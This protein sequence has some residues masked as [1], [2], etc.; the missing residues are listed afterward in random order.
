MRFRQTVC[1]PTDR[2]EMGH[3][4]TEA[5]TGKPS[6]AM[7]RWAVIAVDS[8]IL[9]AILPIALVISRS[10]VPVA[11]EPIPASILWIVAVAGCIMIMGSFRAYSSLWR[12]ASSADFFNLAIATIA[13]TTYLFIL[14]IIAAM[15]SAT[16]A[17]EWRFFAAF[18]LLHAVLASLV[19][20]GYRL[21]SDYLEAAKQD[22]RSDRL[23]TVFVG[24]AD[25]AAVALKLYRS[26]D[27]S[28]PSIML[29]V[30]T[31]RTLDGRYLSGVR[32]AGGMASIGSAIARLQRSD[33]QVTQGL[34]G[35]RGFRSRA[36]RLD[37]VVR[38]RQLGIAVREFSLDTVGQ[39][40][41]STHA[42]SSSDIKSFINRTEMSFPETLLDTSVAGKRVLVTG[43]A[44]SIGTGLSRHCLKRGALHV[45][46]ADRSEFGVFRWYREVLAP[47][48]GLGSGH[49]AEIANSHIMTRLLAETRPDIVFH[50]AALKH[51]DLV[52][53]N[54]ASALMTNVVGTWTTAQAAIS[55]GAGQFVFVSTDKA[56]D[57][58]TLLGLTKRTGEILSASLDRVRSSD[59]TRFCS[60]R[61]G[62]VFASDGSVI[63]VFEDQIAKGG[64]VTVTDK[65]MKRFFMTKGEAADMLL[66]AA[67]LDVSRSKEPSQVY[68]PEMGDMVAIHELAET[69]IRLTGKAPGRD[70]AIVETG[71]KRGEKL[72]EQLL[73]MGERGRIVAEGHITEAAIPVHTIPRCQ[74]LIEDIRHIVSHGKR[75]V[76]VQALQDFIQSAHHD[77]DQGIIAFPSRSRPAAS[78]AN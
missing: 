6:Q 43:G 10:P 14:G 70:I 18:V 67:A 7:R 56:A 77:A 39:A 65:R 12:F 48:G 52:D 23:A 49:V 30:A 64:P 24:G 54:W 47:E 76:A 21:A 46:I 51:V 68:V 34:V 63:G 15:V 25:E 13:C 37:A 5:N 40:N 33:I 1:G 71:R 28:A 27:P 20:I 73:G 58:A 36:E 75:D 61:F 57:P 50:A 8:M 66:C 74:A 60:V 11:G 72:E 29:V 17:S 42:L 59:E 44:G 69:M 31:D 38:L 16:E 26:L 55:A 45:A 78:S 19:R 35:N 3:I 32:V 2:L 41:I 62:N 53:Q 4:L 22:F 9:L